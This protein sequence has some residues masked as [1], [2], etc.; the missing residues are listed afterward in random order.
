[1]LPPC[2]ISSGSPNRLASISRRVRQSP[3]QAV[4]EPRAPSECV[5]DAPPCKSPIGLRGNLGARRELSAHGVGVDE[6][7]RC[8]IPR[9]DSPPGSRCEREGAGHVPVTGGAGWS[10]PPSRWRPSVGAPLRRPGHQIGPG[11]CRLGCRLCGLLGPTW[12]STSCRHRRLGPSHGRARV[13]ARRGLGRGR[14]PF[15][16]GRQ[17]RSLG[18][19]RCWCF[20]AGGHGRR[21]WPIW[22]RS[23]DLLPWPMRGGRR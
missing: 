16:R 9:D 2:G 8:R 17:A 5:N 6:H 19:C 12:C 3:N 21:R 22:S 1:M 13:R 15:G 7:P 14:R 23:R 20:R 11:G 4:S 10:V 18:R